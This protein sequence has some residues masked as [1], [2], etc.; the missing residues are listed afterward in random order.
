MTHLPLAL[1]VVISMALSLLMGYPFI[2][3]MK[4][5]KVGQTIREEGPKSHHAKAGTPTMGGWIIVVPALVTSLAVGALQGSL[6]PD[7]LAVM[8]VILGCGFFGWL[9]DYLIIKRRQNK[10][11]TARQKLGGVILV[12]I[13]FSAY[14]ALSG[15]GTAIMLPVTHT[16]WDLGWAYY[17]LLVLVIAGSTNAVNLTDGLDGLAAGTMAIAMGG[18]AFMLSQYATFASL[19]SIT[20]LLLALIGGC[21]GFLWFNSHPAQVF[22]GDTGS[23]ALGGAIAGAA[24]MGRLEL[25]LIPLGALFV[26]ETLSVIL[27]VASFKTTGKRIFKMSPLHHHFELSGWAETKVVQRFYLIGLL[28]AILTIALL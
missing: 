21:L 5:W 23:L 27:Q 2:D 15:H 14:L 4:R 1:T 3:Y 8:G 12:G 17:P 28:V 11:L 26:A 16:L 20:V 6:P 13:L 18:L 10:G 24:V 9:D 7:L 19:G 25:F 22:M